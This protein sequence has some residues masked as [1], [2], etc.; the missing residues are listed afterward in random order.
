MTIMPRPEDE[1]EEQFRLSWNPRNE[2][3]SQVGLPLLDGSS[4]PKA[5]YHSLH[6]K[7]DLPKLVENEPF[8]YIPSLRK[9][10]QQPSVHMEGPDPRTVA[11]RGSP[12]MFDPHY[13]YH[14]SSSYHRYSFQQYHTGPSPH[15][16]RVSYCSSREN[17]I[18]Q[19]H[20]SIPQPHYSKTTPVASS[21]DAVVPEVYDEDVLCGRGAPT[22]W[23]PGN[24]LFRR[25]VTLHQP[26]YLAARRA[27]KPAIAIQIVR[28][29]TSQ[30]GRFL[31][32]TKVHGT[33]GTG[34]FGWQDIGE[35]RAYEK[36]CQAL[37]EGAPE[38]RRQMNMAAE[39]KKSSII[40]S[41]DNQSRNS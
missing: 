22:S 21:R 15:N 18:P 35:N 24:Q 12:P 25:L 34:H 30:G 8:P 31:K 23:H 37:R 33:S 16:E 5:M 9:A 27:D 6:D 36:A 20:Y 3:R 40:S 10:P 4:S 19:P 29:V 1:Y 39:A 17:S 26:A 2:R 7:N 38:I 14:P 41:E 11:F 32:R 28:E 13:P